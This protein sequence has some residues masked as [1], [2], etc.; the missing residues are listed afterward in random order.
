MKAGLVTG[1]RQLELREFPE[2]QP[3]PGRAVIITDPEIGDNFIVVPVIPLGYGVTHLYQYPTATGSRP[4]FEM[5]TANCATSAPGEP[6]SPE[7]LS[8][9]AA[10]NEQPR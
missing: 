8:R 7:I 2:P 1:R 9:S 3:E 6:R 10:Q 5:V 4:A